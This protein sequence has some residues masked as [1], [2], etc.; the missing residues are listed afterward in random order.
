MAGAFAELMATLGYDRYGAQGGDW[1]SLVSANLAEIDAAHVCGLHLNFVVD[2]RRTR[3][4]SR[5]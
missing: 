2:P 3:T 1:G 5:R 4:R